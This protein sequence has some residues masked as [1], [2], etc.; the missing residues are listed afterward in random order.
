MT[1]DADQEPLNNQNKIIGLKNKE[2]KELLNKTEKNFALKKLD[3]K[4][5]IMD[6]EIEK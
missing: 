2:S 3:L 5:L 4:Q 6:S 1:K